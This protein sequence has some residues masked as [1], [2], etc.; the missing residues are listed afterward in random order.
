MELQLGLSLPS[1]PI[2]DLDLNKYVNDPKDEIWTDHSCCSRKNKAHK[3]SFNESF[4]I[5]TPTPTLPLLSW[6]DKPNKEEDDGDGGGGNRKSLKKS[7]S[8]T[9]RKSNGEGGGIIGWPPISRC[10]RSFHL[11][12]HDYHYHNHRQQ[13]NVAGRDQNDRTDG[14]GC[15]RLNNS[16]YVKVKMEGVAIGRKVDLSLHRSYQNLTDTLIAMFEEYRP[17]KGDMEGSWNNGKR[18]TF[19]YQDRDGDWLLL[20]DIPWQTFV[21]AV[22]RLKILWS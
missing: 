17:D 8:C 6:N 1:N 9:I 5:V 2:K 13:Q 7:S 12:H 11:L 22:K 19:T 16:M 14:L 3:R 15:R 21:G 20:G 10:R 4:E 18:Y